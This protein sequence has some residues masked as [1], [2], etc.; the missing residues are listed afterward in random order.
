MNRGPH[1][2]LPRCRASTAQHSADTIASSQGDCRRCVDRGLLILGLFL[3]CRPMQ[4]RRILLNRHRFLNLLLFV[5]SY[6]PG[7]PSAQ[8]IKFHFSTA[9]PRQREN[10]SSAR[11][12]RDGVNQLGISIG[13]CL[14]TPPPKKFDHRKTP[15]FT[16][17]TGATVAPR[18]RPENPNAS[19]LWLSPHSYDQ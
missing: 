9:V 2:A 10:A 17:I 3:G 6:P 16:R 5:S 7:I 11:V 14:G 13:R 19:R 12:S 4:I 18:R 15:D 8:H 1:C